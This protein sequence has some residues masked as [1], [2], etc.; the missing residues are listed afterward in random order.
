MD[1]VVSDEFLSQ[2]TAIGE[3]DVLVSVPTADNRH[4]IQHAV[5]AIQIGLAKYFPRERTALM[6]VD[7]QSRD[8]TPQI[9]REAAVRDFETFLA[10][11]P[12]RSSPIIMASCHPSQGQAGALRLTLTAADLLRAKACAVV[13]PDVASLTPE[14]IDA[15]V[16][17]IYREGFDLLTPIYQRHRFEGLLVRNVLA[18]VVHAV[19]GYQIEEPSPDEISFSGV[20]ACHLLTQEVWQEGFM[21]AGAYLWLTT[22][23][24]AGNFRV[25]QSFLGPKV[26]SARHYSPSLAETIQSVVGAL[27]RSLEAHQTFWRQR[28]ASQAVPLFGLPVDLDI[29]S[30][31]LNRKQMFEMFRSGTPAIVSILTDILSP[32]TLGDV[33]EITKGE[34]DHGFFADE[35]WAKVIYE[36][37]AAYHGGVMNRDHLLQ[38]LTPVYRGRISSYLWQNRGARLEELRKRREVL[39][40]EFER[41]KPY[42]IEKWFAET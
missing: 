6:N 5:N 18:P 15:L 8:G 29:G 22:T 42:L 16:R 14:W 4:T 25:A 34:E 35:L 37:A 3:V 20:L 21:S 27:F 2:I 9:V 10:P 12:L 31:R 41:M 26:F 39:H 32:S 7:V 28:T 36:F 40:L 33:M 19:Y 13:S 17:P 24:L 23:A 11:T 1:S 30:A 38:A